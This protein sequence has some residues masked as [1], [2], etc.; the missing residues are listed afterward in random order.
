MP[1]YRHEEHF[2]K[3]S[4]RA[5]AV[6]R[7]RRG[8]CPLPPYFRAGQGF[9]PAAGAACPGHAPDTRRQPGGAGA[10]RLRAGR[11]GGQAG[12]RAGRFAGPRAAGPRRGG[13]LRLRSAAAPPRRDD[14]GYGS[15][16]PQRPPGPGALR[17]SGGAGRNRPPQAGRREPPHRRAHNAGQGGREKTAGRLPARRYRRDARGSFFGP[18]AAGGRPA[19]RAETERFREDK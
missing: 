15:H 7:R 11:A 4:G 16:R 2:P 14:H 19:A 6:L 18:A 10:A 3:E 12:H 17:H 9:H 8:L 5:P 1:E 13:R